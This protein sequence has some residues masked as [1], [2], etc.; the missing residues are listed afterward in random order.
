MTGLEAA[1]EYFK[2]RDEVEKLDKKIGA[3]RAERIARENEIRSYVAE[4]NAAAKQTDNQKVA[5]K[6]K[7]RVI[8]YEYGDNGGYMTIVKLAGSAE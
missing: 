8:V 5:F 6:V 2:E 3:L 7:D 4:M 1:V